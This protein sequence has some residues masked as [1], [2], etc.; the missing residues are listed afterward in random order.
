MKI[1][2]LGT[3]RE[4]LVFFHD[5]SKPMYAP[6][7]LTCD[8][9]RKLGGSVYNTCQFLS[10]KS[11]KTIISLCVPYHEYLVK[12]FERLNKNL[13]INLIHPNKAIDEY[14]LTVIGVMD[15]SD[16]KMISF[17]PN[18]SFNGASELFSEESLDSQ[19][20]YTSMYEINDTNIDSVVS[21]LL[22]AISNGGHSVVDLCPTIS[23]INRIVLQKVISSVSILC[24]NKEEF[25]VLVN[26]QKCTGEISELFSLSDSLQ[27]CF[28]TEAEKGASVYFRNNNKIE[29]Y[30]QELPKKTNIKNSTG[31]GDSFA[32]MVII[33][34]MND[35]SVYRILDDALIESS[36]F[37]QEV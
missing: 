21:S 32:A 3:L 34:L 37:I 15:N 24:G 2:M 11:P 35:Y 20:A 1:S 23:S 10:T 26:S 4:D 6:E 30:K 18:L 7:I 25:R 28:V 5:F 13:N 33:G 29:H 31:A 36:R 16:K 9:A 12:R 8:F 19:I 14:P 17:D 22:S 27:M